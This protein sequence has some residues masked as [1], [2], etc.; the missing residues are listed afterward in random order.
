MKRRLHSR[1]FKPQLVKEA[2]EIGNQAL[3]YSW[4]NDIVEGQ[5]KCLKVIKRQIY[6]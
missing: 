2:L 5:V 6:G 1:D 3:S 4:S